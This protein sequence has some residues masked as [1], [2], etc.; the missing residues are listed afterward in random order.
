MYRFLL[1]R[2]G[3]G[4]AVTVGR[5]ATH[6]DRGHFIPIA[7]KQPNPLFVK[8]LETILKNGAPARMPRYLTGRTATLY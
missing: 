1:Q 8:T 2:Q 4:R 3:K 5:E 7:E 6:A